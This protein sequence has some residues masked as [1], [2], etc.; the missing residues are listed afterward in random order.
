[1]NK[2]FAQVQLNI[3]CKIPISRNKYYKQQ[4]SILTD[5]LSSF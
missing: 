2:K 3:K 5:L 1:M 4:K